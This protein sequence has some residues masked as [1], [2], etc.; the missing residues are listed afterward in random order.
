MKGTYCLIIS[1]KKSDKIKIGSIYQ[2]PYKFKKGHYVY[3]GSAMNSLIPRLSRHLSDEKK[4]HWHIDYLLKSQNSEIREILFT[5]SI[6]RIEC[7]LANSIAKEGLEIE[8]FG[9]SDCNCNSHLIYFERKRDALKSV[10]NA[11]DSIDIEYYDLKH[12]KKLIKNK[13]R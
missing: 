11:Y 9:C 13:K 10:K 2:T 4:M 3:I 7:D 8:R 6:K 5:D 12:F 1:M